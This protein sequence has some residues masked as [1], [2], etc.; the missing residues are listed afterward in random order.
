MQPNICLQ[1][2]SAWRKL[3]TVRQKTRKWET[4]LKLQK[5]NSTTIKN[6]RKIDDKLESLDRQDAHPRRPDLLILVN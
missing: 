1:N 5:S 3:I 4:K 2:L 6:K